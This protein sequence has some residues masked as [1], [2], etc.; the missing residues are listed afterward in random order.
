M[1]Q[2]DVRPLLRPLIE[3]CRR[4][5]PQLNG[6]GQVGLPLV[7]LD[8]LDDGF[9]SLHE[10]KWLDDEL[11]AVDLANEEFLSRGYEEALF[12][13]I[14]FVNV[15]ALAVDAHWLAEQS[16]DVAWAMDA[17]RIGDVDELV[18]VLLGSEAAGVF[19]F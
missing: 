14:L 4:S 7:V 1:H 3:Q 11:A 6:N 13:F 8:A 10:L 9:Y 19:C 2:D 12:Q 5:F 16:Q 18:C 15:Q 17:G